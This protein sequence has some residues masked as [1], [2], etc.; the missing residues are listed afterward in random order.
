MQGKPFKLARMPRIMENSEDPQGILQQVI[1]GAIFLPSRAVKKQDYIY[2]SKY[3]GKRRSNNYWGYISSHRHHRP[4]STST[5]Q[6]PTF[7]SSFRQ[8]ERSLQI[9]QNRDINS[10][11][12]SSRVV[13][14]LRLVS[15][16]II[17]QA[18]SCY[19]VLG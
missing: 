12:F 5:L 18:P 13:L 11:R 9:G 3:P 17:H 2:S 14:P 15:S 10:P 7:S 6:E 19:L 1:K 8:V 4:L 16:T